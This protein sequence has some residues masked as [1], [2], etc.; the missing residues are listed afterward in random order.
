MDVSQIRI[1]R[2][3]RGLRQV[4]LA[5]ELQISQPFV[6]Q[7]EAG[8]VKPSQLMQ[9]KLIGSLLPIEEITGIAEEG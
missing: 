7:L 4:D 3:R 9:R 6:S 5:V 1:L 8:R 2:K